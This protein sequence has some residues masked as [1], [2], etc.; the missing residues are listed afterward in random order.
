VFL[1][2]LT[3]LYSMIGR[4]FLPA[5]N[6]GALWIRLFAP[7]TISREAAVELGHQVRQALKQIPEVTDVVNQIGRPDDGTDI[8]GFDVDEFL[9]QLSDPRYWRT[10]HTIDGL[11][12]KCQV[13]LSPMKGVDFE[14]SQPI[15]D[16]VDEAISGVKGELVVKIYGPKLEELQKY[17]NAVAEILTGIRGAQDVSA[18]KLFGQ[19]ELRFNMDHAL[20]ARYGMQVTDAEDVLESALLGKPAAKMIDDQ[21]R[22]VDILVKPDLPENPTESLLASLP[23]VTP[24][25]ARVPLGDVSHPLL[26]E[27]VA[28]VF[29]ESGERRSAVKLSVRNRAVVEF[30]SEATQAIQNKV[31]IHPPYRF[32][33]AGSFENAA[34]A[35][36]QLMLI[37]PL[38]VVAMIVILFTWFKRW[39]TVGLLL[40]EIPFA[41]VGG[42]AALHLSGLYLSISAVVGGI[43]LIGV[44]LLTGMMLLSGWQH[45]GNPSDALQNEGRGILLS[46]G[47]AIVGLIPASFSHG[48]GSEIARP[49]AVMIV[50]GLCS[51]LFFTLTLLPAMLARTKCTF[52]KTTNP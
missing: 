8:N 9:V 2:A 10:A 42:L 52:V 4:E 18:D 24:G 40:W 5:L 38:C 3:V 15:K 44:T 6:E 51:S 43:V 46:S 12:K 34:R 22:Y 28:R 26:V 13:V 14:Y 30:V 37:V 33:W 31:A 25:G 19:P 20:L 32:E 47:V 21:G 50:G 16:N 45:F 27:G 11:I 17:A 49:F 1:V 41:L 23:I 39:H 7:T 36:H 35:A 29:R 48:I